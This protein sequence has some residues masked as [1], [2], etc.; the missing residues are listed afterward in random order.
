[1]KIIEKFSNNIDGLSNLEYKW[2]TSCRGFHLIISVVY[3][4]FY[5][6]SS[7]V[8][9]LFGQY[10]Y[11]ISWVNSLPTCR[12]GWFLFLRVNTIVIEL[13]PHQKC[14]IIHAG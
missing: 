10:K 12:F 2:W 13:S 7:S 11:K 1:M 5:N 8:N 9:K 6:I 4:M 14:C 3:F